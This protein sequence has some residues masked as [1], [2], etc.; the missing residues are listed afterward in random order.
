MKLIFAT[1]NANKLSEVKQLLGNEF[2]IISLADIGYTK[3]I[4]EPFDTLE[5]NSLTKAK[6]IYDKF[7]VNCF[8][9]DTGLEVEALNGEPGVLSA[10]Y[11]GIE[12]DA[13][14]NM[15]KI[16][17]NLSNKANRNAQFRTVATLILNGVEFQFEGI[18]KGEITKTKRGEDGFGYDPIFKAKDYDNTFAEMDKSTKNNI[19]HRGK[20]ISALVV[21]LRKQL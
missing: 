9:E 7:K 15:N 20:A 2:E 14:A 18:V 17:T 11:A 5:E 6:T 1:N 19:S 16:L 21:F 4:P 10:R 13:N 12:K 3:D 8:A